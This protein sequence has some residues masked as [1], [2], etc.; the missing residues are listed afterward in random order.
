MLHEM[1]DPV[2]T[3]W[4][5][6]ILKFKNK[7][8]DCLFIE[9]RSNSLPI[10]LKQF[11]ENNFHPSIF[12]NSYSFTQTA[13]MSSPANQ[14]SKIIYSAN[15]TESNDSSGFFKKYKDQYGKDATDFAAEAYEFV[16]M[17]SGPIHE[18]LDDTVCMQEKM[19]KI[20]EV[21]SSL[22]SLTVNQNKEIQLT[23]YQ[24]F[25]VVNGESMEIH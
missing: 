17:L 7:N 1:F 25:R 10:L 8:V 4:R 3:D 11:E 22:G 13:I 9:V 23:K 14:I 12:T 2:T 20:N 16:R 15:Y 21:A 19:S 5:S 24:L 18:C 6:S